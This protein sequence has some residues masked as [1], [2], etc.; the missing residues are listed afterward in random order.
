LAHTLIVISATTSDRRARVAT[1][2]VAPTGYIV[3]ENEEA[4]TR[5]RPLFR[6]LQTMLLYSLLI[7][8][9]QSYLI[10]DTFNSWPLDSVETFLFFYLKILA[11]S[12]ILASHSHLEA[13][14]TC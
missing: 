5:A 13:I 6:D 1:L 14:F 7:C 2:V 3:I 8:S 12:K 4:G 11:H 9:M 10:S